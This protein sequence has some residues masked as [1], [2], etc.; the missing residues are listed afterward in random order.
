M[1]RRMIRSTLSVT[2]HTA[3]A[4]ALVAAEHPIGAEVGADILEIGRAHV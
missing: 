2:K 3:A 1:I 4:R